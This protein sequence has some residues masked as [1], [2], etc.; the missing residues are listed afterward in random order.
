MASFRA[1][2]LRFRIC[3]AHLSYGGGDTAATVR[4]AAA[5]GGHL[6]RRA[7]R[8]DRTS[9]VLAANLT[10]RDRE[11]PVLAAIRAA[12]VEVLDQAL[13]PTLALSG[14]Y[15]SAIG[16]VDPEGDLR[17]GPSDRNCGVFDFQEALFRP[18]HIA[19]YR[20]AGLYRPAGGASNGDK[21]RRDFIR[22]G[23][24]NVSDHLPLW[25]E[26]AA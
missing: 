22:W 1:G 6:V 5:L 18:E 8:R 24:M 7:A 12:G 2:S 11:S 15:A 3:T 13:L 14:R 25:V 20:D 21:E 9:V 16:F 17:L 23:V 4:E 26:L 10:L 19:H